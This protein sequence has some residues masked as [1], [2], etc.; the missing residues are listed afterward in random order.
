MVKVGNAAFPLTWIFALLQYY[1]NVSNQKDKK[2]SLCRLNALKRCIK[3]D[4]THAS[5][6]TNDLRSTGSCILFSNN[7]KAKGT[8][9]YHQMPPLLEDAYTCLGEQVKISTRRD[10]K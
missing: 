5:K 10:T 7:K 4:N 8:S 3:Q 2:K 1:T 6:Q 9:I